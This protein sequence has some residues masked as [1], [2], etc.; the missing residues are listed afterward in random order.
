MDCMQDVLAEGRRFRTLKVLAIVTRACV[1]IA[2]DTSLPGTRVTRLL[3]QLIC[4]HG[5]PKRITLDNGPECTGQALDVCAYEQGVARDFIEPGRPM[6]NGYLERFKRPGS[7]TNAS[8]CLHVHW[9][10]SRAEARQILGEGR[11][12]YNTERPHSA[13]CGR[14][15]TQQAL[16]YQAVASLA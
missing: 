2:V 14:T 4:W 9:L 7:A 15:P 11:V 3:D 5:V 16:Y 1:A 10:R 13:L 6:Q 12:S 8:E